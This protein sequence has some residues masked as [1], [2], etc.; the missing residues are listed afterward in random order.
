MTLAEPE[1]SCIV[2]TDRMMW[3]QGLLLRSQW[4]LHLKPEL[5]EYYITEH[6][7]KYNR[8]ILNFYLKKWILQRNAL[9]CSKVIRIQG[10]V[11]VFWLKNNKQT[12]K[13]KTGKSASLLPLINLNIFYDSLYELYFKLFKMHFHSFRNWSSFVNVKMC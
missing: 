5:W 2:F 8:S 13:H 10:W 7:G 9:L 6:K 4:S 1:R 12:N 11:A 3:V